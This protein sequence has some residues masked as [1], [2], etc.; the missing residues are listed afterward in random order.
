MA[1][2][3]D[4]FE[5]P[6][7]RTIEE[8]IQVDQHDQ[9]VVRQEIREYVATDSI[10]DHF[11]QVFDKI[12]QY[13][14]EP[15][16][17]IGI[18]GS[19]LFGSGK[20]SFA[21]ILGY[22][23]ADRPLGENSAA[24][25]FSE[26]AGDRQI[27]SYLQNINAR[28]PMHAVIFDV[29][30][31]RGYKFANDRIT[32]I[33]YKV[34]LRELDYPTD[35]D[36]A[37]LE[38]SLEAGGELDAFIIRYQKKFKKDWSKGKKIVTNALNEA[39]FIL[40]EMKPDVFSTPDSWLHAL[41][42]E[43]RADIDPN[44]LAALTFELAARRRP[45]KGIIYIIDEVGQY[46]SRST[47]KMLDL[48]AIVQAL[49]KESETRVRSRQAVVPA[50][51]VVTSQ[52]KLDEVV[53]ALDDKRIELAR[54]K[55]RFPITVDLQQSD[56]REVTAI[57]VLKKTAPAATTLAALFTQHE[58]RI[59]THC[60]L[61]RTHRQTRVEQH[62]FIDLYPYLPYQIEL[63]IEIVSGLRMRRGAQ[64]HVGGSNR[65]IIKQAQQMLIH[66]QTNLGSR[67][68]GALVT[69]DL[70]FDLLAVGNLLP[71]EIFSEI[72]A[73][74][75]RL[76]GDELALKTAK[77][78]CLLEVVK[79]LPRTTTNIASALH[80]SVE[81]ESHLAEVQKA[82]QRLEEAQFIRDT[83]QGYKLLSVVEKNWDVE[84]S[85]KA[86]REREKHEIIDNIVQE[87]FSD[88]SLTTYRFKNKKTFPLGL[89]V[90]DRV[91]STGQINLQLHFVDELADGP[92]L[93]EQVKGESRR[94]EHKQD[95]YWI[96]SLNETIH[97]LVI[98]Y[99]RSRAMIS[100]YSRIQAQKEITTEEL[101]CL[102]DEKERE[103][104]ISRKLKSELLKAVEAGTAIYCGLEK[105]SIQLGSRLAEMIKKVLNDF[106]PSVYTKL[107]LGARN[108]D[109]RE[110]D[111]L[112]QAANLNGLPQVFYGLPDGL[113]L[114][115]RKDG[116]FIANAEAPVL[117]EVL[118]YIRSQEQYG[119]RVTG[120]LLESHFGEPPYGWERDLLRMLTAF[121]FRIGAIE[122]FH[123]GKKWSS[124][125]D[126]N[127]WPAFT[128]NMA[129]KSAT[130]TPQV[131]IDIS[132]LVEAAKQY[133]SITGREIDVDKQTISSGVIDLARAAQEQLEQLLN[134]IRFSRL[135]GA[136]ALQE[137][138]HFLQSITN[139]S[140]DDAVKILAGQGQTFK[141]YRDHLQ[142]LSEKLTPKN[143][144]ILENGSMLFGRIIPVLQ[145][146]KVDGKIA[147]A[148]VMLERFYQNERL[149]Q[150]IDEVNKH[151]ETVF[152]AYEK[153]YS[154]AHQNR[155]SAMEA[156][157]DVVKSHPDFAALEKAEAE[158]LI[159]PLQQRLCSKMQ[160]S[161]EGVCKNCHA[162]LMQLDSDLLSAN[163]LVDAAL[164]KLQQHIQSPANPVI[165][166]S[167]SMLRHH[168]FR[169][170]QEFEGALEEFKQQVV[171][172]LMEGK[173][174]YLQ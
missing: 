162:A 125:S 23:L 131:K 172:L 4:L 67:E 31:D 2:I 81:A 93:Q 119:N 148:A 143:L 72:D 167:M 151:T 62:E 61:E 85:A 139:S 150:H 133:E 106:V 60:A 132:L 153:L 57:R 11:I 98:D 58:G 117:Q 121:L 159:K 123:Q 65:T 164:Q 50:W 35:F 160:L 82:L 8:V 70:I 29:S 149:Y 158:E 144:T 107:E 78:I 48:Q 53:D 152:A 174:V 68:V 52:E 79:D 92:Q 124:C 26:T 75:K 137:I 13:Q 163:A 101:S 55:D 95:L 14:Q 42:E 21:K 112:L 105:E 103:S 59:N 44:K 108:L 100:E 116:R 41:G 91:L 136:D 157:I 19:G 51:I 146:L 46:V 10:K 120:K 171:K 169:S 3:R 130:F 15:G 39:S 135:P 140:S 129:F 32:E 104:K 126:H 110:A 30:M 63:S 165:P 64:R 111:R 80:P 109:G 84:R 7:D 161:R 115:I 168:E 40:H 83:E 76:P 94:I 56:I 27:T 43:G 89:I 74:P 1:R 49:G 128:N 24:A 173:T 25:L 155:N 127:A 5:R 122:V 145:D 154:A 18:W 28:L 20:S 99:H 73:I 36:L 45:G 114:V 34:L 134:K 142:Q 17:G 88:P 96:F 22:T 33:M 6:I 66:P 141:Q 9:D 87:I 38:M 97:R 156:A 12:A 71:S 16:R 54:L 37:E 90:N 166:F 102:E 113:E 147:E 47:E 77:A 138:D 69:L 86:P 118:N 170:A